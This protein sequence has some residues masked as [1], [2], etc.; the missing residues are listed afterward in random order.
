VEGEGEVQEGKASEGE[1]LATDRIVEIVPTCVQGRVVAW[2]AEEVKE[3]G[4]EGGGPMSE[5][6]RLLD[7]IPSVEWTAPRPCTTKRKQS[8]AAGAEKKERPLATMAFVME[9]GLKPDLWVEF[10]RLN[11]CV[12]YDGAARRESCV[13]W[14]WWVKKGKKKED[15]KE[16]AVEKEEQQEQEQQ[17]EEAEVLIY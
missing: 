17:E 2:L 1:E 11:M 3:G 14:K 16:E 13:S 4:K 6:R 10:K 7:V 8:T 15:E 9:G 5:C 12:R